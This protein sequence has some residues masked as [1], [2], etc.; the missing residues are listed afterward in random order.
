MSY[1]NFYQKKRGG[2]AEMGPAVVRC[3]EVKASEILR[4]NLRGG[5][6]VVRMGLVFMSVFR[7]L[8]IAAPL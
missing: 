3:G 6:G 7:F 2:W 5:F 8:A 4:V 1:I